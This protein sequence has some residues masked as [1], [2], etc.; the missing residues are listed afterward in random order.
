MANLERDWVA[1]GPGCAAED[2]A[3]DICLGNEAADDDSTYTVALISD[4]EKGF[5]KVRHDRLVEAANKIWLSKTYTSA[6]AGHV[7]ICPPH[8]MW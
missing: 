6:R 4:L 8:Q 1:F 5:E 2:A 7:Q 3:Y